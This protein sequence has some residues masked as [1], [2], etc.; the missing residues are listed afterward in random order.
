MKSRIQALRE[1]AV[2]HLGAHC[3]E[4][5]Y[6]N[7][8]RALQIDHKN[9]G[10]N[11]ERRALTERGVYRRVFEHPDDYRVLCANCNAI[12]GRASI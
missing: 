2:K 6:D 5:G 4:C 10:G 3:D 1:S 8:I 7:D 9:G 12:N 11:I